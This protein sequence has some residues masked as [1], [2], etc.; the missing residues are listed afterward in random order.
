MTEPPKPLRVDATSEEIA[1][2]RKYYAAAAGVPV[3][4]LRSIVID[5]GLLAS[6]MRDAVPGLGSDLAKI[7]VSATADAMMAVRPVVTQF[8]N[9]WMTGKIPQHGNRGDGVRQGI[10]L[11]AAAIACRVISVE[12]ER[13][14]RQAGD[15]VLADVV[16]RGSDVYYA[17]VT[18]AERAPG[19]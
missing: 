17:L 18:A 9:K 8:K 5:V 13:E 14:M 7:V 4:Q 16:S 15:D 19:G 12:I 1:A 6:T 10:A 2:H 3:E 11:A